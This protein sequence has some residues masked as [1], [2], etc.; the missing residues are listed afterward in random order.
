MVLGCGMIVDPWL[1]KI[2]EIP[3]KV[4]S[5]VDL[6]V[7]NSTYFFHGADTNYEKVALFRYAD[8]HFDLKEVISVN[9]ELEN[10]WFS[11]LTEGRNT[12]IYGKYEDFLKLV[13]EKKIRYIIAEHCEMYSVLEPYF[14]TLEV[15]T[16]NSMGKIFKIPEELGS[17]VGAP[18]LM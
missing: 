1:N 13:E 2:K 7:T 11:T 16:E 12:Y 5:S 3:P 10:G 9:Y 14:D 4:Q 8:E 17:K 6:F 18:A 15:I